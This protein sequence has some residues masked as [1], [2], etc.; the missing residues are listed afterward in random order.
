MLL[1]GHLRVEVVLT[2]TLDAAQRAAIVRLCTA[3][4]AQDFGAL[5]DLVPVTASHMLVRLDDIL[6]GHT[7]WMPRW[8]QPGEQPPL[9]TA[10]VDAVATLPAYQG[11]G[12]GSA[13]MQRLADQIQDYELGGLATSR[14]AFYERLGWELWRGPLSARTSQGSQRTPNEQV[15]ILR[16]PKT[17]PHLDLDLP[18]SVEW[19]AGSVW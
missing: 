6:I 13:M 5:F 2:T 16:L 4:F 11:R 14:V 18:L 7:A 19:R 9:R 1:L 10:Y 12:I 15:M 8:L 3:A 17:P